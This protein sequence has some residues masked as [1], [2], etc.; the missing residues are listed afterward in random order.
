MSRS[1]P[2]LG[3]SFPEDVITKQTRLAVSF[4]SFSAVPITAKFV[5]V[6]SSGKLSKLRP[7]E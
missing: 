4:V 6:H 1:I 3:R 7:V 5:R 2:F